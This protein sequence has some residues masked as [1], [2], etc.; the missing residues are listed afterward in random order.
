MNIPRQVTRKRKGISSGKRLNSKPTYIVAAII[1]A[2][3]Y[4]IYH[5][6][7]SRSQSPRATAEREGEEMFKVEATPSS[8]IEFIA[9]R[10][11]GLAGVDQS[12]FDPAQE[13][14]DARVSDLDERMLAAYERQQLKKMEQDNAMREHMMARQIEMAQSAIEGDTVVEGFGSTSEFARQRLNKRSASSTQGLYTEVS[15]SAQGLPFNVVGQSSAAGQSTPI[16]VQELQAL[17][18]RLPPEY[19]QMLQGLIR[20]AHTGQNPLSPAARSMGETENYLQQ[21]TTGL[22]NKRDF[23][24]RRQL[25]QP[26]TRF[27]IKTGTVLPAA[28]ISAANSDLPGDIVAQITQNVYDTQTG[29]Y[30]LVPQGTK[31]FGRYDAFT[32]LGQQRLLIVWDRL[33]FPD[34]ET[35]DIGGMQATTALGRQGSGTK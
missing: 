28:M 12:L 13:T 20:D 18:S 26:R 31:L 15:A 16:T 4:G 34:A 2:T 5:A 30:L 22:R 1:L 27:E 24:L 9:D 17:A 7:S 25:E 19:Q 6:A 11:D 14:D 3:L 23:R 8:Q 29:K 10:P 33:I 21:G 32:Q 35:L